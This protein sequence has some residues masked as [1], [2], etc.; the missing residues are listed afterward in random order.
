MKWFAILAAAWVLWVLTA[1]L[2]ASQARAADDLCDV[3]FRVR[4]PLLEA[5]NGNYD[6]RF[7]RRIDG[8]VR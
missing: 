1:F 3:K 8:G 5:P 7:G 2:V 6:F 4:P